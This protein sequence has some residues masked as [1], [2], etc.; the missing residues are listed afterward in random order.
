MVISP[1]EVWKNS[2][3]GSLLFLPALGFPPL[4]SPPYFHIDGIL[5]EAA[6]MEVV[7]LG[8]SLVEDIAAVK[9][10]ALIFAEVFEHADTA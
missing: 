9:R 10:K 2:R 7:V 5:G 1:F 6:G 4:A 3:W 8:L